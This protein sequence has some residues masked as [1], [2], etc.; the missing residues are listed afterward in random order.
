MNQGQFDEAAN[1]CLPILRQNPRDAPV[2]ALYGKLAIQMGRSEDAIIILRK[3]LAI[4][5]DQSGVHE[6]IAIA[7]NLAGDFDNA[8]THALRAVELDANS[9]ESRLVLSTILISEGQEEEALQYIEEA[10][11][12]SYGDP[13]VEKGLHRQLVEYGQAVR[14]A[15]SPQ[16]IDCALS[17]RQLLL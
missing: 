16:G 12:L 13:R 1:L 5:P 4:A 9:I 10:R 17:R 7:Y 3:L 15:G 6:D 14:S 2:I 8:R 11:N